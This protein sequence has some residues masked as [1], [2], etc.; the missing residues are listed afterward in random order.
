MILPP[1]FRGA[2]FGRAADGNGRDDAAARAVTSS[3]LGIPED[4][5]SLRQMHGAGVLEARGPGRVGEADALFTSR[6]HLPMVV[7]TADC[8]PV[9]VEAAEAAGVAHAGWRGV[10]AGVVP[11]LLA[12]MAA[13][14]SVPVRAAIGPGIGPCCFEVGP[15]VAARFPGHVAET[16]WGAPSVDLPSALHAQLDG[17]DLW[18]AGR[19]TRCGSGFHSYRRDGTALRQIGLAWMP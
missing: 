14:G 10:D 16:T 12:A 5:S 18:T 1:G 3:A 15:E 19:C 6:P 2:A 11:A 17:L 8:F 4:G 9:V 13:A 7:A